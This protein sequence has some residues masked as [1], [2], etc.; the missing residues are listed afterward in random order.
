MAVATTFVQ[1]PLLYSELWK[2]K[3]GCSAKE[4]HFDKIKTQYEPQCD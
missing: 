2:G 3:V 4:V 1:Y